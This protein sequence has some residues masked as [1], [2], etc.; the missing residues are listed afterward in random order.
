MSELAFLSATQLAAKI[1]LREISSE[2]LL[3]LYFERIDRYN[4]DLNAIVVQC[5]D[6]AVAAAKKADQELAKG[7]E[8]LGALHG[9]PMTVKESYGVAGTPSTWGVPE[10]KDNVVE[11][12]A[13]P[14]Q[15]LK[16]AGAIIFGKTNVPIRLADF[17]SY[18]DVY[19]TTNNP[20]DRTRGPGGSSGGSAAALAA[21]LTGLETGSDI[22]GSIRNPAHYCGVF[23]HKP[24]WGLLPPRGHAM[25]GVLSPSDISVIGPLARSATDLKTAVLTMGGPDEIAAR[26][27]SL[28][29]PRLEK[30]PGSMKIAVWRDDEMA[31]VAKEVS[32]R[33]DLIAQTLADLGANIDFDARPGFTAQHSDFVYRNLLQA[34]MS[35]R[36]SDQQYAHALDSV[37]SLDSEDKS[38]EA[39][40]RRS[41]VARFREWNAL[42]EQRTHLRWAWHEFFNDYDVLLTPVMAT[43]AFPHDHRPMRERKIQV[44]NSPQDYGTQVFWSGLT[45]G[46]YLPSTV[47]PTGLNDQGLPIGVQIAGPEYGDLITIEVAELLEQEGFTFTPAPDFL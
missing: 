8:Q 27:Q 18:N 7:T 29:L 44:D 12:D 10:M 22:G 34:T 21:G 1:R 36:L 5:R 23:G 37:A 43:A 6:E 2:E 24:T 35:A 41:Q 11:S 15:R 30:K 14:I 38:T 4:G 20:W 19:G 26:G 46:S 45:C 31:P 40:V 3:R 13:L 9:V 39:S 33:V 25:P 42:N 32:E 47:I 16:A 17:Q 28:N